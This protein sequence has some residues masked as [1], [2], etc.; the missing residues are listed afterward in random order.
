MPELD[1]S[2]DSTKPEGAP[3]IV[4]EAD[5]KLLKQIRDDYRFCLD[6]WRKNREESA[7]DMDYAA[8]SGWTADDIA[9]RENRPCLWP[10]ELSQY[11][12]QANN[13]MR[14]NKTEIQVKPKGQGATDED[15]LRREN[16]IRAIQYSS[17]APQGTFE[18]ERSHLQVHSRRS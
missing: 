15:A 5:E 13:N 6:Y 10:D 4:S 12:K 17:S 9:D 3:A 16:I 7:I 11:V 14:Q 8:G 2:E 18:T 1:N